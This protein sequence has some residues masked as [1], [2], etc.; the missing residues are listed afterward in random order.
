MEIHAPERPV[1][2][3]KE[4]LVHIG[5]VTIGILIALSLEGLL[6]W[7]HHR[8]LV[9]EARAN[10]ASEI[11]DN[12]KELDYFIKNAPQA[13][14]DQEQALQLIGNVLAHQSLGAHASLHL[15]AN[16]ADLNSTSWATAQA[17]GALSFMEYGEVKRYARIYQLQEEFLRLQQ[18]NLDIVTSALAIFAENKGPTELPEADL[19]AERSRILDSLSSIT[20]QQQIGQALMKR[21]G[22]VSDK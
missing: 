10:I 7:H 20:I 22:E 1:T 13:R 15:V 16:L 18:K 8:E 3:L 4:F 9:K 5:I 17:V 6:E 19:R 11:Q 12:R 14:K 2:S 21:Y